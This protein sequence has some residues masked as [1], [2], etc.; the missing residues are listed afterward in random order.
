MVSVKTGNSMLRVNAVTPLDASG[1]SQK[2]GLGA[3]GSLSGAAN[4]VVQKD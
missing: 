2:H 1:K 3:F 4:I